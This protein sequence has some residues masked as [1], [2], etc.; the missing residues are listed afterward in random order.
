MMARRTVIGSG[1]AAIS[2]LLGGC[3]PFASNNSI[4]F[5]L[6]LSVNTPSGLQ[7]AS[8]VLEFVRDKATAMLRPIDTGS[9]FLIGQ[10]P[11]LRFGEHGALFALLKDP[12][13]ERQVDDIVWLAVHGLG[14]D[15]PLSRKYES[16]DWAE[17]FAEL[18]SGEFSG[19]VQHDRYPM[20]VWIPDLANLLSAEELAPSSFG[21]IRSGVSFSSL[22]F[23]FVPD[24]TDIDLDLPDRF[25]S[26]FNLR[27]HAFGSQ[28]RGARRSE[29]LARALRT[30]NFYVKPR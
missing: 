3:N 25:P 28:P 24:G 10:A 19:S 30:D 6:A 27:P 11:A 9:H 17:A 5:R 23:Q 16:A 8:S 7:T 20:F 18:K 15:Q 14:L 21:M 13:Y 22:T 2:A 29:H 12:L 26:L 1:I 4:R